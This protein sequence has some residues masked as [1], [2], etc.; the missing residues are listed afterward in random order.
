MHNRHSHTV[1]IAVNEGTM[2][3]RVVFAKCSDNGILYDFLWFSHSMIPVMIMEVCLKFV[4]KSNARRPHNLIKV[5]W[6]RKS[7]RCCWQT[8]K[9]QIILMIVTDP[10]T[11]DNPDCVNESYSTKWS[12]RCW[13][14]LKQRLILTVLAD[15]LTS[16]NPVGVGRP[17]KII[18]MLLADPITPDDSDVK[19]RSC[20]TR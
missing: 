18:L 20:R 12:W 4:D 16:N 9:H 6:Y 13:Q 2:L 14:I 8:L 7:V 17:C 5:M 10:I 11:S 15:S 3:T 19:D 1:N